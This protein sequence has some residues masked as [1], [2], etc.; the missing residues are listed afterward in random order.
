MEMLQEVK[1]LY[2]NYI[3]KAEELERNRKFSDGLFGLGSK[4]ADDPCHAKFANDL[5]T[6]LD[7][8]ADQELPPGEAESVL[9]YIYFIPAEHREPASIY[10]MLLAVHGLT[11]GMIGL[12]APEEASE[13]A[14]RYAKRYPRWERLPAQKRILKALKER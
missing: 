6:L 4:P 3:E 2:R 5:E 13:L 11:D 7:G 9:E 8:R 14:R 1:E 10:W 12:L